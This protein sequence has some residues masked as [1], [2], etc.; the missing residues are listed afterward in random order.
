MG[1]RNSKAHRLRRSSNVIT[2]SE[3]NMPPTSPT[4]PASGPFQYSSMLLPPPESATMAAATTPMKR[5]IIELVMIRSVILSIWRVSGPRRGT[6]KRICRLATE[7]P[8]AI[9]GPKRSPLPR[10]Q[11]RRVPRT[12]GLSDLIRVALDED[13]RAEDERPH[14]HHEIEQRRDGDAEQEDRRR[15]EPHNGE[16]PRDGASSYADHRR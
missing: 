13:V 2:S 5:P 16:P 8:R 9:P 15:D 12:L 3:R 14:G 7:A 10:S 4:P 6:V 1:P 11:D